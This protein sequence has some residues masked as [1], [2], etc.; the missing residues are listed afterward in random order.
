MAQ[1]HESKPSMDRT[2]RGKI[3]WPVSV[4]HPARLG[5]EATIAN[6]KWLTNAF[7]IVPYEF[8]THTL[9]VEGKDVLQRIVKRDPGAHAA[10]T[11]ATQ[12]AQ[13]YTVHYIIR[14]DGTLTLPHSTS[15]VLARVRPDR[16][17]VPGPA[18]LIG[19]FPTGVPAPGTPAFTPGPLDLGEPGL[20]MADLA[21]PNM[22]SPLGWGFADFVLA[23]R[24]I[25]PHP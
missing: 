17:W 4:G 6:P 14:F 5:A 1:S 16:N 25:A 24:H 9:R 18:T 20:I 15:L 7:E 23:F 13:T 21:S 19:S 8:H 3:A 2:I 11:D 12:D 22:P 10:L